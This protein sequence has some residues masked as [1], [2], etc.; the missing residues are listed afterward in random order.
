MENKGFITANTILDSMGDEQKTKDIYLNESSPDSTYWIY[1][2]A[3]DEN[4]RKN[5]ILEI[6]AQEENKE[7]IFSKII[8]NDET[9]DIIFRN[10]NENIHSKLALEL[11]EYMNNEWFKDIFICFKE[12][13]KVISDDTKSDIADTIMEKYFGKQFVLLMFD[14]RMISENKDYINK[15]IKLWMDSEQKSITEIMLFRLN[16]EPTKVIWKSFEKEMQ[17]S[18]IYDILHNCIRY[19]EY[20]LFW[21]IWDVSNTEIQKETIFNLTKILMKEIMISEGEF[22]TLELC[23]IICGMWTSADKNVMDSELSNLIELV[24]SNNEA[25][26]HILLRCFSDLDEKQYNIIME[27]VKNNPE[28]LDIFIYFVSKTNY[29][30]KILI[31]EK[32]SDNY[33]EKE[34]IKA[35]IYYLLAMQIE[36]LEDGLEK[37][38]QGDGKEW[39]NSIIETMPKYHPARICYDNI[40]LEDR[41]FDKM[42]S[43]ALVKIAMYQM[44]REHDSLKIINSE[45]DVDSLVEYISNGYNENNVF[46]EV[47]KYKEKLENNKEKLEFYLK[48]FEEYCNE[49]DYKKIRELFNDKE[50]NINTDTINSEKQDSVDFTLAIKQYYE[51]GK[52]GKHIKLDNGSI[53]LDENIFTTIEDEEL[54]KITITGDGY[55]IGKKVK[56][57]KCQY[58]YK[59]PVLFSGDGGFQIYDFNEVD[60]ASETFDGNLDKYLTNIK[61]ILISK[62]KIVKH[63]IR[64]VLDFYEE[65]KLDKCTNINISTSVQIDKNDTVLLDVSFSFEEYDDDKFI[66]SWDGYIDVIFDCKTDK[67]EEGDHGWY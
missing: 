5:K 30:Q 59:I 57:G 67:I 40:S 7:K 14:D 38:S 15:L 10:T 33:Y 18:I 13:W 65:N 24:S 54:G 56:I 16:T 41:D 2:E 34:F 52:Q 49:D 63:I 31:K 58:N 19:S 60:S 51:N 11:T 21:K 44:I 48:I 3:I 4:T 22:H 8:I 50:D 28:K 39:C 17:L 62:K 46:K 1:K 9:I 29:G 27:K 42:K 36:S 64:Y 32:Q 43:V 53:V 47:R 25:F 35:V 26:Y 66:D 23:E 20:G 12:M 55:I 6:L 37:F 61:K 45:A